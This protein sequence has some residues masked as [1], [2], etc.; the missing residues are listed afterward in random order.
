MTIFIQ[1]A[2]TASRPVADRI[3]SINSLNCVRAGCCE[4]GA[5]G[6]RATH[7]TLT[8]HCKRVPAPPKLMLI[9]IRSTTT[10]G[11][12][13]LGASFGSYAPVPFLGKS[14]GWSSGSYD[15]SGSDEIEAED[16]SSGY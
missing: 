3:E 6:G 8:S 12:P 11:R 7:N 14:S 2:A 5:T 15:S 16:E 10:E 13:K 9:P 1:S 4:R